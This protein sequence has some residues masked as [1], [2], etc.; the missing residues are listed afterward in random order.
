M[1][2]IIEKNIHED[3]D[4][5]LSPRTC[6]GQEFTFPQYDFV[7]R[8]YSRQVGTVSQ[9]FYEISKKGDKLTNCYNDNGRI[10]V[11]MDH[12]GL[13]K[14]RLAMEFVSFLP[15]PS[16][17]DG[18]RSVPHAQLLN[19]V[20]VDGPTNYACN[21]FDVEMTLPYVWISAYE[22]AKSAGYVGTEEDYMKA[23]VSIGEV[24]KLA[25]DTKKAVEEWEKRK[26][27]YVRVDELADITEEEIREAISDLLS[28][29]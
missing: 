24:G 18:F 8:I 16:Y 4:F 27:E 7:G 11:V 21:G 13:P 5:I 23:L 28:K 6:S 20:L 2:P 1:Y 14:G 29:D 19:I 12:H 3:F 22:L 17:P 9:K 10:H 15:D 26:D 25:E